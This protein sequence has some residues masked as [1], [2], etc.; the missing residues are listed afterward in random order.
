MLL[1]S[2]PQGIDSL[3]HEID[4]AKEATDGFRGTAE[5]HSR[6]FVAEDVAHFS[7][8]IISNICH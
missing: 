5:G 3:P 4:R 8:F 7:N 2:K 6:V 1:A